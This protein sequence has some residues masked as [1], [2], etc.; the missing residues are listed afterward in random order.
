MM[1]SA[2]SIKE[3]QGRWRKYQIWYKHYIFTCLRHNNFLSF[4]RN[5][6]TFKLQQK[7]WDG[8]KKIH[9]LFSALPHC[10]LIQVKRNAYNCSICHAMWERPRIEISVTC[11]Y[12][13]VFMCVFVV[14]GWIARI[15]SFMITTAVAS[16]QQLITNSYIIYNLFSSL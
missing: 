16:S 12:V 1:L 2:W 13:C 8:L 10:T 3:Y 7:I 11:V 6:K 14:C 15:S 5:T 9:M 4:Y